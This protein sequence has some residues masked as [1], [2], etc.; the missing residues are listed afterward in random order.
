MRSERLCSISIPNGETLAIIVSDLGL[1]QLI[2]P[3]PHLYNL[4]GESDMR[5][6]TR[7]ERRNQYYWCKQVK[8]QIFYVNQDADV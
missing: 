6:D 1:V 2:K 5:K 7:Q 3:D 8:C 4:Y